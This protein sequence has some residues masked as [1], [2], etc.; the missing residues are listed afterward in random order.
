MGL[1]CAHIKVINPEK[2]I[3]LSEGITQ[4]ISARGD[5]YFAHGEGRLVK[6]DVETRIMM[7]LPDGALQNTI[8]V[9][10]ELVSDGRCSDSELSTAANR[11]R[12]KRVR[13]RHDVAGTRLKEWRR[14]RH[15]PVLQ[16]SVMCLDLVK[17][18]EGQ[19]TFGYVFFDLLFPELPFTMP[20]FVIVNCF[21]DGEGQFKHLVRI[22][23]P[24]LAEI[25]VESDEK[26]FV[27]RDDCARQ[28]IANVF[29]KTEFAVPGKYWV[30][31]FLDGKLALEYPLLVR[32]GKAPKSEVASGTESQEGWT[33][34]AGEA[35]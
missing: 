1:Q 16:F 21:R 6:S 10:V 32:Q 25:L 9:S 35:E 22:L 4:R 31:N 12:Q 13:R 23:K 28:V 33:A 30:Q 17:E 15:E 34:Q 8:K 20:G 14:D 19:P 11:Q 24:G 26:E 29:E 18:D 5:T 3:H 27:L 2:E 7:I